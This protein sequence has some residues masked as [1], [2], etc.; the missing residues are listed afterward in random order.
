MLSDSFRTEPSCVIFIW[1]CMRAIHHDRLGC[2][3]ALQLL[4]YRYIFWVVVWPICSTAQNYVSMH[5]LCCYDTDL[6]IWLI[7]KKRWGL[8]RIAG[9]SRQHPT[10]HQ[11]HFWSQPG[12]WDQ[13]PSLGVSVTGRPCADCSPGEEFCRYWGV[14]DQVLHWLTATLALIFQVIAFWPASPHNLETYLDEGHWLPFHPT[15][16]LGFSK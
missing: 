16:L 9:R 8:L 12:S 6:T 7:P 5:C 13:R 2:P 11:F 3:D 15:V 1:I 14:I 4:A 10:I